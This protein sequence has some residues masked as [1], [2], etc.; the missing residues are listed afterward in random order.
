MSA[1]P[2]L[3]QKNKTIGECGERTG[4]RERVQVKVLTER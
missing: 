3:I 2:T 1:Q 4:E